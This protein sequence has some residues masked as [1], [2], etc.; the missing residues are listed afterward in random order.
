MISVAGFR[1]SFPQF[2]EALF[3]DGRVAF[4]LSLAGKAMSEEKWEDLYEE[5]VCLYAAHHLTLEA[6]AMKA[7]D[8]AEEVQSAAHAFE[9]L[10]VGEP[11]MLSY[12][13][14]HDGIERALVR[15][16]KISD[17]P[18]KYPRRFKKIQTAPL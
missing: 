4:Y 15:L 5:G 6:A 13:V 2:T 11:E 17:T 1:D 3:P 9:V 14:P 10:G 16:P 12:T 7:A 18:D 8:C